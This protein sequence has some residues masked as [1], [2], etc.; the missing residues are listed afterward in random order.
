MDSNDKMTFRLTYLV[1]LILASGSICLASDLRQEVMNKV[2]A[3]YAEILD[4]KVERWEIEFKRISLPRLD[5]F[6]ISS[7]RGESCDQ[8]PRGSRLCWVEGVLGEQE[9]SLP[10]TI[11]VKTFE[12]LPFAK[13]DLQSRDVIREDDVE[14]RPAESTK[15]G[16]STVLRK[17]EL[18]HIWATSRISAGSI[19]EQRRIGKLPD[20]QIGENVT[21]I[22]RVGTVEI[23]TSGR[24]LQ[25]A[26]IG[27]EIP[28][29]S[30]LTK[31]RLHGLVQIKKTVVIVG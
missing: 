11:Y 21:I 26:F 3:Y 13:N 27:D 9:R 15:L 23:K 8:T 29:K 2:E 14:W 20:V 4:G 19:I 18:S 25:D 28:V 22:S 1:V 24:A 7:V 16:A 12:N 10:V 17:A 6:I 5:G 30:M 31:K